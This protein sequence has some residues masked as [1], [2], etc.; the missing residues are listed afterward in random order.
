VRGVRHERRAGDEEPAGAGGR[1]EGAWCDT[2]PD[3]CI[4]RLQWHAGAVEVG[5]RPLAFI[6]FRACAFAPTTT[7][8][9]RVGKRIVLHGKLGTR[10]RSPARALH[11]ASMHFPK[12]KLHPAISQ[13]ERI[14]RDKTQEDGSRIG[15]R[16]GVSHFAR[17]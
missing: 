4:C 7:R 10:R 14:E 11:A 8:S 13:G 6:A 17:V 2:R 9:A 5:R 12:A 1:T 16:L 3:A 15:H